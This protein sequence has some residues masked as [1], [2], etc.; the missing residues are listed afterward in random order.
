MGL[1]GMFAVSA[2]SPT[3]H[4]IVRRV[5]SAPKWRLPGLSCGLGRGKSFAELD[6][7][8]LLL[9]YPTMKVNILI[10]ED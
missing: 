7:R 4:P 9:K 8:I 3:L 5:T 6:S 1:P 2:A 10:N